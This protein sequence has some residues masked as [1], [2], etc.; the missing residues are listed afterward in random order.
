MVAP[1]LVERI[2]KSLETHPFINVPLE[3]LAKK[4]KIDKV[5]LATG[6]VALSVWLAT[7]FGSGHLLL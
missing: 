1:S 2:S 6:M 7:T 4:M 3:T 5:Y